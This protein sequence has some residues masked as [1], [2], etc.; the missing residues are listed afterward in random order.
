MVVIMVDFRLTVINALKEA[1]KSWLDDEILP[2][3]VTGEI[4]DYAE[5]EEIDTS[6]RAA[7]IVTDSA[8]LAKSSSLAGNDRIHIIFI[9]DY[10]EV[11][12]ISGNIEEILP[13][14][15][16]KELI[17]R[18]LRKAI[19]S[20]KTE[21]ELWFYKNTLV[22]TINTVPDM[23]WFKRLDGIHML[24]NDAFTEI[25][26]KTKDDIHGKDHFYIWDV[27]R[28]SGDDYEFACAESE[29]IAISTGK[30]YICD[31][32][33][34]TS[35]GMKQL[36][37]Y[38][39][40]VYDK[41]GNVF[42]TVGV[43]HDVTNFSNL[44]IELSILV[45]N[46]PFPMTIFTPDWKVVRMNSHFK[47]IVRADDTESFSY[48]EWKSAVPVPAGDRTEDKSRHSA[49]REYIIEVDGE[50]KSF[51]LTELEIRDFFGNVSGYFCTMQDIT[52]Q[53][54]YE[55]SIIKAANTDILT[56]MY[57]RRYFYSYLK[58]NIG[59]KFSLVYMDLDH[60]KEINDNFGHSV[61]DEVLV[62][63]A[64]LIQQY[65]PDEMTARLGGD[66]FAVVAENLSLEEL[67]K[68]C[69][70]FSGA[71]ESTFKKYNQNTAV[72]FGIVETDGTST[73]I[74][75]LIHES[76]ARMYEEKK[77]HHNEL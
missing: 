8:E 17:V 36:T 41:Y 12:D 30:T 33:V 63:T 64:E 2:E 68:R 65:F 51:M 6:D 39:T 13:A 9:G 4:T 44:G 58:E 73:D 20:L 61:G 56:N 26:H 34:K 72:S 57:N 5:N 42:G 7:L 55:R 10:S 14:S 40:P 35:D 22:T 62:K 21:F 45:E 74:D 28:P 23:L 59:K 25:V 49:S 15:Y 47:E 60:F 24:V 75:R 50:Q 31:E 76:D 38:K 54:A 37:T 71:V 52:Y 19:L 67:K 27:P 3:G 69:N 11:Q 46:M 66:E 48:R 70:D 1:D 29:E 43:G 16:S 32:P 53:R 18:R 77:R